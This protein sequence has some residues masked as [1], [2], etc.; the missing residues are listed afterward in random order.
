M[1]KLVIE[2]NRGSSGPTSE[3]SVPYSENENRPSPEPNQDQTTQ[4][5][6][7][8]GN[9]QEVDPSKY[10]TSKFG[11]GQVKSQV[12]TLIEK[13]CIIKGSST[14]GSVNLDSLTNFSQVIMPPK[15]KAPEFIKYDGIG[16]PCPHLCLFCGKKAPNKD[17]H[18]LLCQIFPDS[19]TGPAA[20]WY[21]R[22]EKTFSWREMA[23]AFLEYY[24][25]NTVVAP[26][27]TVL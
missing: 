21:V 4:P 10:K 12:E 8:H 2:G 9:N 13:I 26:D 15:L 3:G 16:D 14:Q 17:N 11:Y 1:Q 6:T 18:P 5:F 27:H 19:L 20:T 23:N 24:R 7:P 22:L 25:F